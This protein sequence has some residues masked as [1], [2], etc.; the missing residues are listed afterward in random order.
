MRIS[1]QCAQED[2]LNLEGSAAGLPE[3]KIKPQLGALKHSRPVARTFPAV[4]NVWRIRAGAAP[5]PLLLR[6]FQ[7]GPQIGVSP[8]FLTLQLFPFD[9]PFNTIKKRAHHFEKAPSKGEF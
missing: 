4:G 7:A 2:R 8:N 6:D 9:F 1:R 5:P 3:A